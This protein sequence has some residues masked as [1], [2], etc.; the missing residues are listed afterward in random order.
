MKKFLMQFG[1]AALAL[2]LITACG[3]TDE[4]EPMDNQDP[5]EE[6]VPSD[7]EGMDEPNEQDGQ[8]GGLEGNQPEDGEM[9]DEQDNQ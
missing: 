8:N 6:E 3:T 9:Q 1:T 4:E 7:Q 5:I 2:S